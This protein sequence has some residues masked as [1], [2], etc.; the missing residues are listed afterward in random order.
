MQVEIKDKL[1]KDILSY[2]VLNELDVTN[3]VNDLLNKQFVVEKYGERPAIFEQTKKVE[4]TKVI[5]ESIN[6]PIKQDETVEIPFT[7]EPVVVDYSK[8]EELKPEP[9]MITREELM[10]MYDQKEVQEKPKKKR[11]KLS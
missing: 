10:E 2:C 8:T 1:Y 6:E 7:L 3:F 4:Q 5:S 11:R 9:P